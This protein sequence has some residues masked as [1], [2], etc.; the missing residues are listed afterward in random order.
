M[1]IDE[2]ALDVCRG[3]LTDMEIN[4]VELLQM[5]VTS[6]G[7]TTQP[8]WQKCVDNVIMNPPFGTKKNEGRRYFIL[9]RKRYCVIDLFNRFVCVCVVCLHLCHCD[10]NEMAG[11]SNMV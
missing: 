5:D 4:N 2:D 8:R 6:I 9:Y 3:N 10:C 11:L 1:D 7:P